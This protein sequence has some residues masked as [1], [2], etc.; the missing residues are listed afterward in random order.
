MLLAEGNLGEGELMSQEIL[1]WVADALTEMGLPGFCPNVVHR[2]AFNTNAWSVF[3]VIMS[4]AR[5]STLI[6]FPCLKVNRN[7][8]QRS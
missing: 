6:S 7:C 2:L 5:S 1:E 8:T 3:E 4:R